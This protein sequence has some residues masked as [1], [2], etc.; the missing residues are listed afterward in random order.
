MKLLVGTTPVRIPGDRARPVIQN[1]GPGTVYVDTDGDVSADDG[2]MLL[3]NAVYEFPTPS[4]NSKG[5]WVV[6][7]QAGTDVRVVRMG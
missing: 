1:L 6:A 3:P 4:A 5:I 2:L 7:D